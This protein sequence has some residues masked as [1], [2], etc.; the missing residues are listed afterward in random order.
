MLEAWRIY[1]LPGSRENWHIDSGCGTQI[2]NVRGYN[3]RV[4]CFSVDIGGEHSPRA[5][6]QINK[7]QLPLKVDFHIINGVA[8]FSFAPLQVGEITRCKETDNIVLNGMSD[9]AA[10]KE[11]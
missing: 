4:A 1:R 7:N 10:E 9:S 2:V 5:W 6:I 11:K 8:L 3:C